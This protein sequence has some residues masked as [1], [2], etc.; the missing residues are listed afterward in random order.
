MDQNPKAH[1]SQAERVDGG[2]AITFD[3]G[4]SFLFKADMLRAYSEHAEDITDL[5]ELEIPSY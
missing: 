2:V 5:P 3:D 4:R 1:I